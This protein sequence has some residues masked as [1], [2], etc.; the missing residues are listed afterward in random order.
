[1][2]CIFLENESESED[3]T[4]PS[5]LP[6]RA[7]QS[8]EGAHC[9]KLHVRSHVT[10]G[11]KCQAALRQLL[12]S[13]VTSCL[14]CHDLNQNQHSDDVVTAAP[15]S[16]HHKAFL[17]LPI[18]LPFYTPLSSPEVLSNQ[19]TKPTTLT[20]STNQS[21]TNSQTNTI[22]SMSDLGRKDIHDST[23][24]SHPPS[25][26]RLTAFPEVADHTTPNSAKSTTE[27]VT[28]SVSGVTDKVQR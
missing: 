5:L 1:M 19:P 21:T 26:C 4:A 22:A 9:G 11:V 3:G 23:S 28:D 12:L 27:K 7:A 15:D 17:P 6:L 24:L 18:L 14:L 16:H 13:H 8:R 20:P 25:H 10:A 2:H